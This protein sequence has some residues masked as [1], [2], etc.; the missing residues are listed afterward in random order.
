MQPGLAPRRSTPPLPGA[1]EGRAATDAALRYQ[2]RALQRVSRTF[3]LTIPQLPAP[4]RGVVGNAYLL[5]RIADTI[6]DEPGLA[7]S[8]K[9]EYLHRFADV[10]VG[11]AIVEPFAADLAA[12]LS[13]A[14]P[15]G[16]RDLV[17]NAPLVVG[18]HRE[19]P[20]GQRDAVERCVTQ[21]C[22]G[23]A[24]FVGTGAEGLRGMV[25]V[26][27]YCHYVAGVVGEMVTDLLCDYSA[28]IA[29]RRGALFPLSSR[30]GRGLQLVNILKDHQEDLARGV[31]WLPRDC[32]H[33]DAEP[34]PGVAGGP[35]PRAADRSPGRRGPSPSRCGAAVR[36]AGSPG[37][38]GHP[39]VPAMD[40]GFRRAYPAP[41]RRE[42]AVRQGRRC[43]DPTPPGGMPPS[44]RR[45]WRCVTTTPCGGCS[46]WRRRRRSCAPAD[47]VAKHERQPLVPGPASADERAIRPDRPRAAARRADS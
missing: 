20:S 24:E 32:P 7:A 40:A 11:D 16:E 34:F 46:T 29:T 44:P 6:E 38:T 47:R 27:R 12:C 14:T 33:P 9:R 15:D 8:R 19:L 31:S 28:E 22:H 1:R 41:H 42:P 39:S 18:F 21:M 37:G 10:V 23:M 43:Q 45:A 5:C 36:P 2:E 25:E 17:A 35:A 13:D 26:D 4:L 3:A 30:F